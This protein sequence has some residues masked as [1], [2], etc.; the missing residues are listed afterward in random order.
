[1]GGEEGRGTFRPEARSGFST[2]AADLTF[3]SGFLL[4]L[5]GLAAFAGLAKKV[6]V[7]GEGL[8]A[9]SLAL[10]GIFRELDLVGTGKGGATVEASP[11]ITSGALGLLARC[12]LATLPTD[13]TPV[14]PPLPNCGGSWPPIDLETCS[15]AAFSPMLRARSGVVSNTAD[16]VFARDSAL[17]LAFPF[18]NSFD[19]GGLF[20]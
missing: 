8:C 14:R 17:A 20:A 7:Y 9:P 10:I 19:L 5:G 15:I 6:V 16:N 13:E 2:V 11:F 1:M 4:L 3:R 18:P 12:R